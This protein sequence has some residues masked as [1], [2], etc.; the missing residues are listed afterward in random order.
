VTTPG[1]V[2]TIST[3]EPQNDGVFPVVADTHVKGGLHAVGS[4]AARDAIP[5]ERRTVGMRA[6]VTSTTPF[7]EFELTNAST[8]TLVASG[9]G[10]GGGGGGA[11]D[12]VNGATGDVVLTAGS[13]GAASS[14]DFSTHVSS[15]TAH[16][17]SGY[18]A[19]LV[20]AA[21]A[22][23]ARTVLGLGSAAVA[24]TSDFVLAGAAA[25]SAA[26]AAHVSAATAH[27]ISGYG[28]S[29]VSA[30]SASF[31]RTVLG[32]GSA[33]VAATTDF[34]AA[35]AA[36]SSADFSTH[37]SAV[38]AHGI[39]GYGASL[40]SAA[41]AALA[42]TVLGLGSAAVAATTDFTAA[43][44]AASSAAF[45]AHV[46]SATAHGISGYGASLVSAASASFARTVLGLGSAAL[47]ATTDFVAAGDVRL[48]ALFSTASNG[49]VPVATSTT[50]FLR[51]D[52]TW[53]TPAGG[54]GAV[55][56][57]NGATGTVVL[58][59][60]SVGA[61]SSAE[62]S[63]HVSSI[64]PHGIS[65]YGASLVS[66]A[67]ASFAR[68]VLGL[69]SAA[70]A[71]TTD[72]TAAGAA[73]SSAAFA[74]H[75]SAATAHGISGYGA[76]LVSA[77]SAALARTVLGLGSAAVAATTDFTAAGV[78][79]SSSAFATHTAAVLV[80]GISGYGA[81]LVSA[82]SASFAR[83][84]LGLG[85]AALAATTDFVAAGDVR[86][87]ALFSTAS[88]GLVPAATSTT[89]FL[90]GDGTW[91]TPA[92]G[93][94]SDG[95]KG[96]ITVSGSAATFAINPGRVALVSLASMLSGRL[97][98]RASGG[99]GAP[100]EISLRTPLEMVGSQ[101]SLG[102]PAAG[103]TAFVIA[104]GATYGNYVSTATA[105]AALPVFTTTLRGVVP[106][107][108]STTQ[109]LRGDGTWATPSG[110][111]GGLSD[112][113]YG[114]ITVSGSGTTLTLNPLSAL[115]LVTGAG[116]TAAS[117]GYLM[118]FGREGVRKVPGFVGPS[119]Q[120]TTLQPFLARNRVSYWSAPGNST[121][122]PVSTGNAALTTTGTLTTRSTTSADFLSQAR[123]VGFV[124]GATLNG[125]AGYRLTNAPYFRGNGAG[126]GGF[127]YVEFFAVSDAVHNATA[128]WFHGL[129]NNTS[130]PSQGDP[131]A[132][133]SI[134][135]LAKDRADTN[136][137]FIHNDGSGVA[138][139]V[140]TGIASGT[141]KF[142]QFEMFCPPQGA[143]VSWS[144]VELISGSGASGFASTDL[145]ADTTFLTV[146]VTMSTGSTSTAV[147][148][149][150][151]SLYIET[152][153]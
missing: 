142:F 57:V 7:L 12:S 90:R 100:Q 115:T 62:F 113:G 146:N 23:F 65:G 52:G 33:A 116:P 122:A 125:T 94:L 32:L 27:G 82:A 70:L 83:T 147:G 11:V 96:D 138:T 133:T 45:A 98:G 61:A 149:D 24:S 139:K 1:A 60:G 143:T 117:P 108:T 151:C 69:G 14:A 84:V 22:S 81:S 39:S 144:V 104:S 46:S 34:V 31:A 121:T 124:S 42:R 111:G 17:I 88:N 72:F 85:S 28:A 112:G 91:A 87:T 152:D 101:L 127:H 51:G 80:H 150:L 114:D 92:G 54:G 130:A 126:R 16:G 77:A 4:I 132:R 18:G 135:G 64:T 78:A 25:S 123:R 119:G 79:A 106:V 38:L 103:T 58:T 136:I 110:G 49:L 86:L 53:A 102:V 40:V 2:L 5:L 47:A 20:S 120:D 137:Q 36:A 68:T 67:S 148:H 71:A 66:A 59:A 128:Q 44:A 95:N 140:D 15:A 26:F 13:V 29:L 55:D 63:T 145:P 129:W 41:S 50:Q 97:L 75:V 35:G 76:S 37:T 8:W 43:G 3:I 153:L 107:A 118:L 10:G 30:A 134:L 93:G 21:S 109:F 141:N 48:T 89:Q 19:S 9:G 56:S 73:A 6:V 74:A 131:S 105:A 99:D